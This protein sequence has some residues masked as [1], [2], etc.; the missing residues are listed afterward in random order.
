VAAQ[1]CVL[2]AVTAAFKARKPGKTKKP[3]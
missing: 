1:G 2:K 3:I